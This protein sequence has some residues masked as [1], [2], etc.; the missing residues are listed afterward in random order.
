VTARGR[1]LD[2][3]AQVAV[4]DWRA[5]LG[6]AVEDALAEAHA[7]GA[8]A[9]REAIAEIAHLRGDVCSEPYARCAYYELSDTI[10]ARSAPAAQTDA[11]AQCEY[12]QPGINETV[13]CI[14]DVGHAG[15]HSFDHWSRP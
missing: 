8:A 3:L 12:T 11:P 10:R 14:L 7:A 6:V 13:R 15:R 5:N 1:L 9:E 4:S 2:M